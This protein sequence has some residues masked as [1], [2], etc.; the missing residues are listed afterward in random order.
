MMIPVVAQYRPQHAEQPARNGK[1]EDQCHYG[2]PD[3]AYCPDV[4]HGGGGVKPAQ[5]RYRVN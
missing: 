2:Q 4:Y 5:P 1:E 3:E